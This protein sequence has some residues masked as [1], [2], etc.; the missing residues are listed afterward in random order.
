MKTSLF[1]AFLALGVSV[2]GLAFMLARSAAPLGAET[3]AVEPVLA[4][5]PASHAPPTDRLAA[6]EDELRRL[7]ARVESLE[8]APAPAQRAPVTQGEVTLEDLEALRAELLGQRG[9]SERTEPRPKR[10]P[11]PAELEEFRTHVAGALEDIRKREAVSKLRT[12]EK[13]TERLDDVLPMYA[14]R[15]E[16]DAEATTRLRSVLL[17]QYQRE[18]DI[19]RRWQ[20]GEDDEVLGEMKR[21]DREVHQGELAEVLTPAQLELY[22]GWGPIR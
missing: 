1:V 20:D 10:P 22:R 6:L 11:S 14:K 9:G 17:R 5:T 7:R 4:A 19:V 21:N 8:S 2:A 18:A 16:L 3:G 13:R 12:I 15:L